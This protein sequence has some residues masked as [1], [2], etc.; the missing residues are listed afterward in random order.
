MKNF[1]CGVV[2]GVVLVGV[3]GFALMRAGW[4]P[5]SALPTELA[6]GDHASEARPMF[7]E[8]GAVSDALSAALA[9]GDAQAVKPLLDPAVLI[10]ESGGVERS[11]AEYAAHHLGHDMK[12]M[13]AMSRERLSRQVFDL[14]EHAM[15]AT[16]SRLRGQLPSGAVD[17][18]ST[19]T[20]LLRRLDEQ[21][22]I[23]HIHWSSGAA[24]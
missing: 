23:A 16:R 17:L 10:F 8:P 20:L 24:K 21:W 1:V 12:F 14:G 4:V 5:V 13:A 15:V 2:S 18:Y 6:V 22:R 11:L 7:V 9:A 3:L 19:E